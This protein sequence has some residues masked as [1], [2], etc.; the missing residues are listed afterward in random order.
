MGY[1]EQSK[2]VEDNIEL[3][4]RV[5][6]AVELFK[7]MQNAADKYDL[8]RTTSDFNTYF[9]KSFITKE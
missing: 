8:A 3:R 6:K 2:A 5:N 1:A 7:T 4:K 9:R